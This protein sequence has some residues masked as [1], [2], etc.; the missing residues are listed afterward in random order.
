MNHDP[1]AARLDALVAQVRRSCDQA[2][3]TLQIS[4]VVVAEARQTGD[5]A[6]HARTRSAA[7]VVAR[8]R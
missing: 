8:H 3:K 2:R 5:R 1:L 6:S 4:R 7:L